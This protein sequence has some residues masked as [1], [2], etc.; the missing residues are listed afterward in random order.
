MKTIEEN[1]RMRS[2]LGALG[3]CAAVVAFVVGGAPSVRVAAQAEPPSAD[4]QGVTYTDEQANRGQM[5]FRRHCQFCHYTNSSNQHQKSELG[6]GMMLGPK[7]RMIGNLGGRAIVDVFP[8]VYH[9]YVRIRDG[10]PAWDIN[11]ASPSQK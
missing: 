4:W 1:T 10:M 3:V 6:R 11:A 5:L 9:L 8:S 7:D 2:R